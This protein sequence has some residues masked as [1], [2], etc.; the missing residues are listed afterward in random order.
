MGDDAGEQ[1]VGELMSGYAYGDPDP[2]EK[3]PYCGAECSADFVDVGVGMV[4]CGPFNC[5]VCFASQI[6]PY[7]EERPLT[8]DERRTGWYAPGSPAGSSANVD[9]EGRIIRHFDADTVV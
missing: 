9:D 2:R 4:Q 3:C 6:G 8:D 7:D 5:Q 1:G